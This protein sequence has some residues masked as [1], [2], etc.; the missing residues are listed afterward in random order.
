MGTPSRRRE[1]TRAGLALALVLVLLMPSL[2]IVAES[3]HDCTDDQCPVCKVIAGAVQMEQQGADVPQA[4]AVATL[5]L[6]ATVVACLRRTLL[7][8]VDTPVS[9][10]VRMND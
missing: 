3:H 10:R 4:L 7:L 5:L 9:L 2:F 8:A 6:A 1:I